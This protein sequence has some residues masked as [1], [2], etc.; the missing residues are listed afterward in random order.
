MVDPA[1]PASNT[2]ASA[3]IKIRIVFPYSQNADCITAS[4]YSEAPGKVLPHGAAL[5]YLMRY[6]I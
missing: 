3:T 4:G 5:L 2:P 6:L 1:Q